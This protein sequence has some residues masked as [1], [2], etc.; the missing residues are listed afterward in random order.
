MIAL[1]ARVILR[2]ILLAA[3]AGVG[4][5][6]VAMLDLSLSRSDAVIVTLILGC[7]FTEIFLAYWRAL[8]TS[9]Q[10]TPVPAMRDPAIATSPGVLSQKLLR[11]LTSMLLLSC[12]TVLAIAALWFVGFGTISA[13]RNTSQ[14]TNFMAETVFFFVVTFVPIAIWHFFDLFCDQIPRSSSLAKL[15]SY[16]FLTYV[17][18]VCGASFVVISS[19]LLHTHPCGHTYGGNFGFMQD[20]S[21]R[22]PEWL[23][24]LFWV[25]LA[26][27][28]M[29]AVMRSVLLFSHNP[30]IAKV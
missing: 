11:W 10:K 1:L 3:L 13:P 22:P 23:L 16:S 25:A 15:S 30:R 8:E 5:V 28:C 14:L 17:I 26:S 27:L 20:C 6:L 2:L 7:I 9:N 18:L 12:F 4:R 29:I 19:Q 24:L 21:A